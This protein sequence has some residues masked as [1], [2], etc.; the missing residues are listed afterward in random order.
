VDHSAAVEVLEA[1][2]QLAK[3][4]RTQRIQK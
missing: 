1:V 3:V 2:H 4:P